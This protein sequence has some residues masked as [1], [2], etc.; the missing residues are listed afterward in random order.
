MKKTTRGEFPV[1][2]IGRMLT[3]GRPARWL[4]AKVR[5]LIERTRVERLQVVCIILMADLLLGDVSLLLQPRGRW[6]ME[7]HYTEIRTMRTGGGGRRELPGQSFAGALDSLLADSATRR[8][9]DSLLRIRPGL[10]DTI[11]RLKKMDSAVP[12]R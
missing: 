7:P 9:W 6:G 3:K 4:A 10:E 5:T 2:V 12:D 1:D 8:E 11:K